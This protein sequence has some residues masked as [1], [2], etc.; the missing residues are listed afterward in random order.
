[1]E[2]KLMTLVKQMHQKFNLENNTG[3]QFL[4]NEEKQFRVKALREEIDEYE[5]SDDLVDEF[6]ALI[7]L[8]VFTVGTFERHGFPMEKGFEIVMRKNMQKELG[9]NGNKR[10]GFKRDLV[11]PANWV[12]PEQE[13][14]QLLSEYAF[15]ESSDNQDWD[16][17]FNPTF[18]VTKNV[19]TT[20]NQ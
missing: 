11:K 16:C 4:D 6:D 10:G 15:G 18:D 9:Q 20:S 5:S 7:D 3:P 13:L 12:G 17:E 19:T 8:L 2:N 1:M 14:A